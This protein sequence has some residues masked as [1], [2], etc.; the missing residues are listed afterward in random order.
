[1]KL[2]GSVID[3]S[4]LLTDGETISSCTISII[5]VSTRGQINTVTISTRMSWWPKE[6][7]SRFE[8]CCPMEFT[9]S[10]WSEPLNLFYGVKHFVKNN[11]Q[12]TYLWFL[13]HLLFHSLVTELNLRRMK[14][15]EKFP[16]WSD[17]QSFPLFPGQCTNDFS[18]ILS[19]SLEISWSY[20]STEQSMFRLLRTNIRFNLH[21]L[22][23]LVV[24]S[25]CEPL[26]WVGGGWVVFRSICFSNI[27]RP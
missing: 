17:I 20:Y 4:S 1:M 14:L 24:G 26:R 27:K 15:D 10:V 21:V 18:T 25:F 12:W 11:K 19:L 5:T 13:K 3:I 23:Q 22:S 7:V 9:L 8:S 6:A 2:Q 16:C